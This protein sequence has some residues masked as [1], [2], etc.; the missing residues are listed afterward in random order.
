MRKV[1]QHALASTLTRC[2]CKRAAHYGCLPRASADVD[3]SFTSHALS[4]FNDTRCHE[5]YN[6]SSLE[7]DLILAWNGAESQ[8]ADMR[9]SS[10][11]PTTKDPNCDATYLVKWKSLSYR[12]LEWVNHSFLVAV[13]PAKLT[14]FLNKG[15]TVALD[16]TSEN[17][18]AE[19]GAAVEEEE[20]RAILMEPDAEERVPVAWRTVDRVLDVFYD[21]GR[22]T[23]VPHHD[24]RKIP[25]DPLESLAQ[26]G[27]CYI[28]WCGLPY[29][30]CTRLLPHITLT[31]PATTEEPPKP[32]E[33]GYEK[34]VEAYKL[35]LISCDPKMRVPILNA[36]QDAQL[37]KSRPK[38]SYVKIEESQVA[39][40]E[41]GRL[42]DFQLV[43]VNFLFYQ[44]L[45]REGAILGDEMGLGKTLQVIALLAYL[46]FH[47]GARPF[48]VVVPNSTIGNC[49]HSR[50][51]SP[52]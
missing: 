5:C 44:W 28:K 37:K 31:R 2:R 18:I 33:E 27:E 29:N 10:K 14:N 52:S 23:L 47:R 7:V 38:S 15:P 39:F 51:F 40:L 42:K 48:L 13:A 32:G 45:G 25:A 34:F 12:R 36:A 41:N 19:D 43:G 26:V 50:H 9:R 3:T 6:F 16:A 11:L 24:Y 8:E 46:C 4:Y 22:A 17:D 49:E 1:R 20:G 35:Y 30:Q 21:V